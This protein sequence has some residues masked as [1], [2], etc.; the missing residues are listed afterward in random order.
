MYRDLEKIN[1]NDKKYLFK[2]N[3]IDRTQ[4]EQTTEAESS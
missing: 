1:K 2:N 3:S 4:S